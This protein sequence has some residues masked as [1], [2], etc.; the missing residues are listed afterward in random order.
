MFDL[1]LIEWVTKMKPGSNSVDDHPQLSPWVFSLFFLVFLLYLSSI[2]RKQENKVK[3]LTKTGSPFC[4]SKC[5]SKERNQY[6]E[7]CAL[8]IYKE[9]VDYFLYIFIG[10][11]QTQNQ[12][13]IVKL[14]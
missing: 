4:F 5:S 12:G 9:L 1:L 6:V 11:P 7:Y 14:L 2:M 13:L 8:Q 10:H 3:G